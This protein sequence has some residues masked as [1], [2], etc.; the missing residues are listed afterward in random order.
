MSKHLCTVPLKVVCTSRYYYYQCFAFVGTAFFIRRRGEEHGGHVILL[1][2]MKCGEVKFAFVSFMRKPF[3]TPKV[4]D[5][6]PFFGNKSQYHFV[7]GF[8]WMGWVLCSFAS[9]HLFVSSRASQRALVF[10]TIV[11]FVQFYYTI[12]VN[13]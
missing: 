13:C 4:K 5:L 11:S 1:Y 9:L 6:P 7:V 3:F 8:V 12:V 2:G 10:T